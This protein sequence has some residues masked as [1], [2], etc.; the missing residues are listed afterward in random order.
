MKD[1]LIHSQFEKQIWF[2]EENF[3]KFEEGKMF[4]QLELNVKFENNIPILFCDKVRGNIFFIQIKIT[5]FESLR[6]TT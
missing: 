5:P 2:Q 4:W 6:W 3:R 1:K